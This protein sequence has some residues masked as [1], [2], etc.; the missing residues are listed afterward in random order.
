MGVYN[1][2][3]WTD[4]VTCSEE[5]IQGEISESGKAMD[6]PGHATLKSG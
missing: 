3:I 5:N 6:K 4:S 1:I 2:R